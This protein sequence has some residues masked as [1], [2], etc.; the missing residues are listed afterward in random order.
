MHRN[1]LQYENVETHSSSSQ[2]S[3]VGI[4]AVAVDDWSRVR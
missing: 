3:R 4:F 2:G 1:M